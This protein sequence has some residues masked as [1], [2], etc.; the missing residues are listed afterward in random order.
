MDEVT[1]LRWMYGAT[2]RE[3]IEEIRDWF[4]EVEE[5]GRARACLCSC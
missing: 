3:V 1:V 2:D 5:K 4:V